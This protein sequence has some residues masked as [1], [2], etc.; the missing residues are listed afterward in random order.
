MR[1]KM[2]NTGFIVGHL[3]NELSIFSILFLFHELTFLI[4]HLNAR[5]INANFLPS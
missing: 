3:I 2:L 1:R 4:Y 5:I